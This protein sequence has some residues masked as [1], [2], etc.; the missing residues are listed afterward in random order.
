MPYPAVSLSWDLHLSGIGA[1]N[2]SASPFQS[3]PSSVPFFLSFLP[4]L[5][6]S[7]AAAFSPTPP[8]PA[9]PA[10]AWPLR[11]PP[12]PP[13]RKR[14]PGACRSS[15]SLLRPRRRSQ[16]RGEGAVRGHR[17]PLSLLGTRGGRDRVPLG[18]GGQSSEG[19]RGV[20]APPAGRVGYN[21]R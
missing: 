14:Q 1:G 21:P 15:W 20:S 16:Q 9:P 3:F 13:G 10:A 17:A 2:Q 7:P 6:L 19:E 12:H 4:S 5:S 18:S 8:S 11:D